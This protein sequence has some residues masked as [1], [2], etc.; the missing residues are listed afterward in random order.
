MDY[1]VKL[2]RL[3]IEAAPY[4]SALAERKRRFVNN[5]TVNKLAYIG[6]GVKM[7]VNIGKLLADEIGGHFLYLGDKCGG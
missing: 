2:I 3:G 7:S 6:K 1:R 4:K 5:R